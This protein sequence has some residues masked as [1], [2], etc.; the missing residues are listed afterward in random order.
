MNDRETLEVSSE[1]AGQLRSGDAGGISPLAVRVPRQWFARLSSRK[2]SSSVPEAELVVADT[3]DLWINIERDELLDLFK[4]IDGLVLN[5]SE[6]RLLTGEE[7]LVRAG[8]AV[9]KHGPEVRRREEG[10]AWGD[11]LWRERNLRHARLSHARRHRSYGG[12]RQLR[13][14]HDGLPGRT[15]KNRPA[16]AERPPWPTALW[17]PVSRSRISASSA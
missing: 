5:D 13:R 16:N 9:R 10:G 7:N 14:R 2:C 4:R 6:A 1:R 17:W 8:H 15:E 12:R 11:V 3:M